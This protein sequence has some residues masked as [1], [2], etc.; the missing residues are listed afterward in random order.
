[1][2]QPAVALAG[3]TASVTSTSLSAGNHTVSASYAGATNFVASTGALSSAYVVARAAASL[4]VSS[5]ASLRPM[6]RPQPARR[7]AR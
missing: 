3:G 2:A 6:L 4:A 5:S 1:V 7:R